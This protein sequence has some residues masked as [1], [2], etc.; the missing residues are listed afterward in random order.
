MAKRP[1]IGIPYIGDDK[2]H[3][4]ML[5]YYLLGVWYAGGRPKILKRTTDPTVLADYMAQCD[6]F[7]MPGGPDVEP[8]RYHR[9]KEPGCGECDLERDAFELGLLEGLLTG[10]KPILGICRGCQALA[11]ASGGTLIQDIT[12]I[13]KLSHREKKSM[14]KGSHFVTVEQE[15][16]LRGILPADTDTVWV[17]SLH[18]QVVEQPG[19][20]M[21]VIARSGD[22]FVEAIQR[23]GHPFCVGLQWHPEQMV[24]RDKTQRKL[25]RTFVNAC[26]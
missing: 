24:V 19:E 25:L 18:H 13:Q 9:E 16:V 2:E 12:P 5:K 3:Q 14:H 7:L 21:R 23:E 10:E 20:K 6:G 11:V 4:G 26:R 22:G 15:S 17:N 1:V 8:E